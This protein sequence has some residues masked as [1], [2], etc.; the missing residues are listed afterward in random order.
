MKH[1]N[2]FKLRAESNAHGLDIYLL[3]GGQPRYI[4]TNRHSEL[5]WDCL[6]NGATLGELSRVKPQGTWNSQK[7]RKHDR[8]YNSLQYLLNVVDEYLKHEYTAA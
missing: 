4:T 1:K 7:T 5:L 2:Q 8:F 6:K 3:I